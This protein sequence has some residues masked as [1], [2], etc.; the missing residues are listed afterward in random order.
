MKKTVT[1]LKITGLITSILGFFCY[2]TTIVSRT[3]AYTALIVETKIA[4]VG[5][6]VV[7]SKDITTAINNYYHSVF[8][9]LLITMAI[10]LVYE[11]VNYIL[12]LKKAKIGLV[13]A[14]IIE[15]IACGIL[16][17]LRQNGIVHFQTLALLIPI[18]TGLTNY[19]ILIIDKK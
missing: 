19:L 2:L 10:I 5:E 11:L 3:V 8:W 12:Y 14:V 16:T 6:V 18:I 9:L 7:P 15:I 1:L 17:V 4:E 13:V